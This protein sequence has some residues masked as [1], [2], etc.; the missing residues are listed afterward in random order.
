MISFI[1]EH[2]TEY[3]LIP[4]L[5]EILGKTNS[6]II[7]IYFWST[8][9]G[10]NLSLNIHD[11]NNLKLFA[12]FPRR[13]KLEISSP[14]KLLCKINESLFE[15]SN[16]ALKLGIITIIGIPLISSILEYRNHKCLWWL[17]EETIPRDIFISIDK[18]NKISSASDCLKLLDNNSL[19]NIYDNSK[20]FNWKTAIDIMKELRQTT[21]IRF[22]GNHYKPIY[23]LMFPEI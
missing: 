12:F 18:K 9:E 21:N 15:Y 13:P 7:P 3:F 6:N 5:C 4:Q 17:A 14:N 23:I 11:N 22:Y 1:S 10:N 16:H 2:T 20:S 8:R 19:S